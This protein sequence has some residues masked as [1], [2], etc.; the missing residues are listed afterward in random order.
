MHVL[1]WHWGRFG[2]HPRFAARLADGFRALPDTTVTLSLSR[3]AEIMAGAHK[4]TCEL[5]IS[6]YRNHLGFLARLLGGPFMALGL[7]LRLRRNRPALAVCAAPGPL[8]AVMLLALRLLGTR[9]VVI[10]HDADSHPGDGMPFLMPL[11]RM[12]CR[13][14]DRLVALSTHVARRLTEQAL[15]RLPVIVA[16][17]PPMDLAVPPP[18]SHPGPVRLLFFGRLLPYKGIDLLAEALALPALAG[19]LA[20]RIV[21]SGPESAELDALR[22]IP[23]ASVENRWVDEAE[24]GDLLTWSDAIVLPYTEASQSGVAAAALAAGRVVIATRVGGL[25]EQLADQP[26]VLFCDPNATDLAHALSVL[27]DGGIAP[28][29]PADAARSWR[30]MAET[31]RAV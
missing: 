22:R 29:P 1:V 2:G 17:H 4:P 20:V 28:G 26:G 27:R 5:P 25:E 24:I 13:R 11:Q 10:V 31:L 23:G 6:T 18:Q 3:Q 30:A 16:T 8:D 21:G 15:S 12:L 14:A 7:V 9:L 19:Q